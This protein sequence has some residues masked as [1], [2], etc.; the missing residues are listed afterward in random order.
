MPSSDHQASDGSSLLVG[1]ETGAGR[2][3]RDGSE[4]VPQCTTQHGRSR[5]H[6]SWAWLEHGSVGWHWGMEPGCLVTG[7]GFY[8]ESSKELLEGFNM[9]TTELSLYLGKTTL[10]AV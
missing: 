10:A 9:G 3:F 8:P 5:R 7:F 4:Q 1:G 6:S 2:S